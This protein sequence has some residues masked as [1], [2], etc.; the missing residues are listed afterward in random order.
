MTTETQ[1]NA[2]NR[3]ATLIAASIGF[4]MISLDVT[5]VNVAL[6]TLSDRL[7]TGLSGLQWVVD[8]YTL[9]FACLLLTG[10]ALGDR[11]GARRVFAAGLVLFLLASLAC[12]LAPNAGVL[13]AARFAQGA[14][15]AVQM[16]TSLALV[17]HVY[18]EAKERARAVAVW[19]AVGGAT[20]AAG[21]V[22][23][24][25]LLSVLDWR[26]LFLV[27]VGIGAIA[28]AVTAR[29][30][31]PRPGPG[32]KPDLPGQLLSVLAIGALT[33]LLI[34]GPRQG[35]SSPVVLLAAVVAVLGAAGFVLVEHRRAEP[36]LPLSLFRRPTF[37]AASAVG[38]GL[39]FCFYG[40]LFL[41]TLYFQTVRGLSPL[42]AGLWFVPMTA[43]VTAANLVGGS[44]AAR[45]GARRP[46][47]AGHLV[48]LVGALA[49]LVALTGAP[50]WALWLAMVPLGTGAGLCVPPVTSALLEATEPAYTGVASGE[51]NAARQLGG[52]VGVALFG[53]LLTAGFTAGLRNSL[54][55]AAIVLLAGTLA[56]LRWIGPRRKTA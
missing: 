26:W 39:N 7:H 47:V 24:G 49:L 37:S 56:C 44:L 31:G 23:G 6:P 8:G 41:L 20:L 25:L 13:I 27:N 40:T 34:E 12:G 15:A 35:F 43:T 9:V 3:R 38:F 30:T 11:L 50:D 1:E 4:A 29:A 22:L 42:T 52:T 55:V 45:F 21:P 51:L 17:G 14:G 33:Y 5:I 53:A 28:L 16:P 10:G 36:M 19:A 18:P 46:L 32:R 54:L 48:F 2:T